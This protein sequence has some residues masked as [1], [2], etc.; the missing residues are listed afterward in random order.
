M[1]KHINLL[2]ELLGELNNLRGQRHA[3]FHYNQVAGASGVSLPLG[4]L[5]RPLPLLVLECHI[6]AVLHQSLDKHT[7]TF[8][9]SEL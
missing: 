9:S 1:Q 5:G 2:I 6:G 8:H 7:Q 4:T 3:G